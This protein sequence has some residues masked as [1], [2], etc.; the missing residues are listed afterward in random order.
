MAVI[1]DLDGTLINSIKFHF[2]SFY[3]GL[4]KTLKIKIDPKFVMGMIEYPTSF[5][6]KAIEKKYRIKI[7]KDQIAEIVGFANSSMNED[8]VRK[9][10][11]FYP[12]AVSTAKLLKSRGIKVGIATSMNS[13]QL[14]IFKKV[15]ELEKIA[16]AIT[17]PS[18]LK[19]DK[20][21]PYILNRAIKLLGAQRKSVFYVGDAP[22]DY[23]ASKNAG[24]KFIGV[25]DE[26]LREFGLFF[27][28][29]RALYKHIKAHLDDF[30]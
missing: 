29:M 30:E 14:K 5:S 23:A 2:K 9:G 28:D 25:R 10:V 6:L 21:N 12:G 19:Q 11:K 15:F 7:S 1:F 18:S 26:R 22:T 13:T 3:P 24:I 20:P 27:P 4:I 16:S 8:N 17:N